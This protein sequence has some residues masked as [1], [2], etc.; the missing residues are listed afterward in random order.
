MTPRAFVATS[1]P[2]RVVGRDPRIDQFTITSDELFARPGLVIDGRNV[3][4]VEHSISPD[5]VRSA[6]TYEGA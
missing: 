3:V 6:I 5:G 4:A 1:Q 2:F